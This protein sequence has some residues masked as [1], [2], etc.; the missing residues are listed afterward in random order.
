MSIGVCSNRASLGL[1]GDT[2]EVPREL[3]LAALH[4]AP[5][6]LASFQDCMWGRLDADLRLANLAR[7]EDLAAAAWDRREYNEKLAHAAKFF[8]ARLQFLTWRRWLKFV[9]ICRKIKEGQLLVLYRRTG[10]MFQCWHRQS[11]GSRE[12]RRRRRIAR[13]M[14]NLA[15]L[16][17]CFTRW[18]RWKECEFIV[19]FTTR[20]YSGQFKICAHAMG[21]CRFALNRG[22]LRLAMTLWLEEAHFIREWVNACRFHIRHIRHLHFSAWW[23]LT[24]IRVDRQET[25]LEA[26]RNQ[27]RIDQLAKS[28]DDELEAR[29]IKEEERLLRKAERERQ[30]RAEKKKQQMYWNVQRKQ[31]TAAA[32]AR[33]LK[34]MQ[35][36]S[37]QKVYKQKMLQLRATFEAK[38]QRL[39]E[40]MAED[41]RVKKLAWIEDKQVSKGTVQKSFNELKRNLLEPP[42]LDNVERE[43][44]MNSLA[45]ITLVYVQGMLVQQGKI[46]SELVSTFS[47]DGLSWL[48][49]EEFAQVLLH[50]EGLNLKP[51]QVRQVIRELDADGDG[52]ISLEELADQVKK[53]DAY[54]GTPGSPW[55][56]YV[57]PA[58]SVTC[59]HNVQ[60]GERVFDYRMTDKKLRAINEENLVAKAVQDARFEA[61]RLKN[62]D[63]QETLRDNCIRRM[64]KMYRNWAG[65]RHAGDVKWRAQM[66][67]NE[68][69]KEVRLAA[70]INIQRVWRGKADRSQVRPWYVR[71]ICKKK[72]AFSGNYFYLNEHTG[73]ITWHRPYLHRRLFPRVTW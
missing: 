69:L 8:W 12:R 11:I 7:Q 17:K 33:I 30:E 35:R 29:R 38:W 27:F 71:L 43:R 60:T 10:S 62:L 41:A 63:W 3:F 59:L 51:E 34:S 52:A 73:D 46:L 21:L 31:A 37:R 5:E 26:R 72:D 32:E 40:E 47:K 4:A 44:N 24:K 13:V 55:K 20:H 50:L 19:A 2:R 68:G 45:N 66:K 42:S 23:Q 65:K 57:D 67:R 49:H 16:R 54:C 14:G 64:Q 58:Q 61:H 36:E 6:I 56:M 9:Y 70:A 28:I 48:S 25:E 53:L 22:S 15:I 18:H 39:E 1:K